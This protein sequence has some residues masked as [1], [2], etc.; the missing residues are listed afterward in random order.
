[1]E[2]PPAAESARC[3][4]DLPMIT[5]AIPC[6]AEPFEP[7]PGT[8]RT[9]LFARE[10]PARILRHPAVLLAAGTPRHGSAPTKSIRTIF[11]PPSL[12]A[13][14]SASHRLTVPWEQR[15]RG[16]RALRRSSAAFMIWRS[17]RQPRFVL[18]AKSI[19]A[20]ATSRK[21]WLTLSGYH[22]L[23]VYTAYPPSSGWAPRSGRD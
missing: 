8:C 16:I 11:L 9:S 21:A 17:F 12:V 20:T 10:E 13:I 15:R 6:L 3:L 22:S 19:S 5:L 1:M 4:A 23:T 18:P 14:G 2:V 7:K